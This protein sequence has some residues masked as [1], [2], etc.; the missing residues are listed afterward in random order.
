MEKDIGKIEASIW[1]R[2]ECLGSLYI[3]TCVRVPD[4]EQHLQNKPFRIGR[5]ATV[6]AP[7][8]QKVAVLRGYWAPFDSARSFH[9]CPK[10]RLKAFVPCSYNE[11]LC[12]NAGP[13]SP[14]PTMFLCV[15]VCT[16]VGRYVVCL[17]LCL[18]VFVCASVF[19]YIC[20]HARMH[21]C[22][23]V[24]TYT[25]CSWNTNGSMFSPGCS[26][27]RMLLKHEQNYA[28]GWSSPQPFSSA[29]PAGRA[30]HGS[31]PFPLRTNPGAS[32]AAHN[33]CC[34]IILNYVALYCIALQY[35]TLH[36]IIQTYTCPHMC[37]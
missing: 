34:D 12:K 20:M 17:Y 8:P 37:T 29:K 10:P 13:T 21:A 4:V 16:Y 33:S 5:F 26:G 14:R 7:F 1:F 25:I 30:P 31:N 2:V 11:M 3:R 23:Y 24:R 36:Y 18:F 22:M 28:L 27:H 19:M 35:I 32:P 15:C 6:H 9:M